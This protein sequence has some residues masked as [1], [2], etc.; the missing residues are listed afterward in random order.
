[1]KQK[2]KKKTV[3]SCLFLILYTIFPNAP[4][5]ELFPFIA[6]KIAK[7]DQYFSLMVCQDCHS[8]VARLWW[9]WVCGAQPWPAEMVAQANF[10]VS[11]HPTRILH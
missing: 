5:L 3:L 11:L 8:Q 10:P 9:W 2:C 7:P 1:M 4:Y 6:Q